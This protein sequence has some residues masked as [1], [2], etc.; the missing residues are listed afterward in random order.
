MAPKQ[1]R[2]L[3]TD[4]NI[5]ELIE[6]VIEE[7]GMMYCELFIRWLLPGSRIIWT[8][9]GLIRAS[10]DEKVVINRHEARG[11]LHLMAEC[12]VLKESSSCYWVY[13]NYVRE[14]MKH[15]LLE[16]EVLNRFKNEDL[17]NIIHRIRKEQEA[18]NA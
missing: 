1:E 13:P 3:P 17:K 8:I 14:H 10:A 11:L 18:R 7:Y 12:E 5:A 16:N 2:T 15:K 6:T 4:D 9:T